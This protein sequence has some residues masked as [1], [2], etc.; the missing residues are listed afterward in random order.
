[1]LAPDA[2]SEPVDVDADPVERKRRWNTGEDKDEEV[3]D[4]DT[5]GGDGAESGLDPGGDEEAAESQ[6]MV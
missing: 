1:M 5:Q 6:Q 3:T 4:H 2:Q